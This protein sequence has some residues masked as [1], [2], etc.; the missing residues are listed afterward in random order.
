MRERKKVRSTSKSKTLLKMCE[1]KTPE[2]ELENYEI[3]SFLII[4]QTPL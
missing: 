2:A 4:V 1:Q 3:F